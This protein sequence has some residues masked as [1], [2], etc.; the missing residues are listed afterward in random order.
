M[1]SQKRVLFTAKYSVIEP[2]F[3]LHLLGSVRDHGHEGTFLPIK[4]YDF[5]PL[6]KRVEQFGATDV[7]MNVY[8]GNHIP[9]FK[10]ADELRK[11]GVKVHIGGPHA[12]YFAKTCG[13]HAD[14]VYKGQSFDSFAA[15]LNDDVENFTRN[16][17]LNKTHQQLLAMAI[18]SRRNELGLQKNELLP[19][20]ELTHIES[21]MEEK[22]AEL[23]KNPVHQRAISDALISRTLFKDTL[24]DTFPK[25]DRATFYRDNPDMADNPIKNA[26]CGEGC[27][28]ACTYC[29]NVA[30]NSP[31]MYG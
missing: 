10:A 7:G 17:I 21:A 27:P 14:L 5:E 9:F 18:T 8:S 1:L 20:A 3:A 29:Y 25:P 22:I 26:I 4:K 28:F 6:Y 15:Y 23:A 12:T 24:S 30:W 13:Q 31:E 16:S 11:R 2:L 19:K